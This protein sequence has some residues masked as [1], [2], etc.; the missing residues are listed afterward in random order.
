MHDRFLEAETRD[1]Q[2]EPD[3]WCQVTQLHGRQEYDA[4]VHLVDTETRR[5]RQ[6]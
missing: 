2:I 4:E 5:Y 3:R 1:K 6:D